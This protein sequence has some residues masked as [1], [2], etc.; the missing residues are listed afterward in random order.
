MATFPSTPTPAHPI[1]VTAEDKTY[2]TPFQLGQEQRRQIWAFPRRHISLRYPP[3]SKASINILWDFFKTVNGRK[4][5]FWF[6]WTISDVYINEWVGRG[7]GSTRLFDLP[8]KETVEGTLAVYVGGSEPTNIDWINNGTFETGDFTGWTQNSSDINSDSG[9]PR[10]GSYCCELIAIGSNI[11]G[12]QSDVI[13]VN[14]NK[15]H[16]IDSYHDVEIYS[17]SDATGTY[18]FVVQFYSDEAG[19]VLISESIIYSATDETSDYEQGTKTVGPASTSP[20]ITFPATT[21]SIRVQ[22]K[23]DGSDPSGTA[24]MDDV[25]VDIV[26]ATK[27]YVIL[28]GGG[29]GESD[30]VYF[31]PGSNV[32]SDGSLIT[33]DIEGKLR[34]N[35]RFKNA[36]GISKSLFATDLYSTQ[37]IELI[38]VK[39]SN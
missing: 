13:I 29:G 23:W 2:I 10:T 12:A 11:N 16:V 36:E 18:K 39:E 22:Q 37:G 26:G 25:T 35:C 1:E 17:D 9:I 31:Q 3:L 19:S 38:E 27:G 33:C 28:T 15:K 34:I 20:D 30:R 8:A 4:D 7:D 5:V 14:T 32:P 24:Y 6:F 21:K